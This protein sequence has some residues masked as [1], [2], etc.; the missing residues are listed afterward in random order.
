MVTSISG[1][2]SFKFT[3]KKNPAAPPPMTAVR[4]VQAKPLEKGG[5]AY[6]A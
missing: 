6:L 3:A 5:A 1:I 2:I 4:I